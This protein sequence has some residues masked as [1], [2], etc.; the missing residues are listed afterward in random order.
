MYTYIH[1]H[2]CIYICTR[3]FEFYKFSYLR[4]SFFTADSHAES[5]C[6]IRKGRGG[7]EVIPR[8]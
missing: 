6:V 3:S 1:T 5:V 2:I 8:V 7:G 4:C